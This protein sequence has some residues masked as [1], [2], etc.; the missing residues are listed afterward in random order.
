MEE[1]KEY[2]HLQVFCTELRIRLENWDLWIGGLVDNKVNGDHLCS[3][4]SLSC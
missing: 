4:P 2:R 3:N 1:E